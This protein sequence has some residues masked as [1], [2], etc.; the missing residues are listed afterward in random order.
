MADLVSRVRHAFAEAFRQGLGAVDPRSAVRAKLDELQ[1]ED[2][3]T[4]VAIGKAARAM[5]DGAIDVLAARIVS[6]VVV[7]TGPPNPMALP[8]IRELQG[9][10]PIPTAASLQAGRTVMAEAASASGTLLVLISGGASALAEVPLE[11]LSLADVASTY[12]LLLRAGL[13]IDR[14]NGIRRHLSALKNGG[15][16]G[17]TR[18]RT[19]TL[20]VADVGAANAGT[21]GSGPTLP[22]SSTRADAIA[23]IEQAGIL[24]AL[25][26]SVIGLLRTPEPTQR[27]SPPHTWAIVTDGATAVLAASN[28]LRQSGFQTTVDPSPLSGDAAQLGQR[29]ASEAVP[30]TVTLRYGETVVR[31]RGDRPGG[32]NQHAALA[33]A[34]AL[35]GQVAAFAALASD[36]RDGLTDAAGAI[37]DGETCHRLRHLGVDA[38]KMLA[39]CRSNEALT[40]S[41]DLVITGPTGTNVADIWM[42]WRL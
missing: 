20:L 15:L 11:G 27:A 26:A 5:T 3:I 12:Q 1:M 13:P 30:S 21:I 39:E 17:A 36:G 7:S 32:R 19:V 9:G 16:A 41:G 2:P 37:V 33:A 4:V 23:I 35:E 31:V 34:L 38:E 29:M 25:P 22:D 14:M 18:A 8:R 40:A 28:F 24:D 6:G 42:S 10:H